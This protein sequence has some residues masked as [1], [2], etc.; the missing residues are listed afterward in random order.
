VFDLKQ[1]RHELHK[2]PEL[3]GNEKKTS[4]IIKKYLKACKPDNIITDLGGYGILAVFDT[5]KPGLSILLRAELDALPINEVNDLKYSSKNMGVSHSCG[6]DGHMSILLGIAEKIK[7]EK[8]N[9]CGKVYLLF[10]PS[11]ETAQGVK[12]I[13]DE[14]YFKSLDI[15]Y[16]FGL[17][18]IPSFEEGE[19]ILRKNVFAAASKGLI[20][21]LKGKTSHAGQPETGNNPI[22]AMTDIIHGL[23]DI[24]KE[25]ES[26]EDISFIT[27]IHVNLGE[28]SFGTSP[29]DGVVM[30]TFRSTDDE[31]MDLMTVKSLS[32]IKT[33]S[34]ENHLKYKIEWVEIFPILINDDSCIDLIE[35]VAREKCLDVVFVDKPFSWTEDFSYYTQQIK[36]S[37]FGLGSGV[38]HPQLHNP[39]YDFPDNIISIGVDL[40]IGI[41]KELLS[42]EK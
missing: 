3:S 35:K 18:N 34:D 24:S 11:E 22:L 33:I 2:Q 19:I 28:I 40:F 1:I 42:N 25:F 10:Q 27:I 12:R 37:F 16:V 31:K 41:V 21:R 13:L 39:D 6:H 26:S 23:L 29:G 36:G 30:A 32:L 38:N 17:H 14:P 20:V 5:G 9:L 7:H 4:E 15:N 8:S